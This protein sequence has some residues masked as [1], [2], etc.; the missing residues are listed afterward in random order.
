MDEILPD[1]AREVDGRLEIDGL[2]AA[3]L[4]ERYGTPLMV[5]DRATLEAR[6]DA[7]ASALG[8]DHVFYAAKAFCCVAIC[9]VLAGLGL[10]IDVCTGG[11]LET[12]F[13]AG[14]PPERILFHG[15]NKSE[16]ELERAGEVGVGRI[17]VDSL[18][19]LDRIAKV[20]PRPTS[21][22]A[23]RRGSRPTPTSS[24]RPVKRIRSSALGSETMSL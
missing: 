19:E 15:N 13:A 8:A 4:A 14:F 12:A 18:D 1:R 3:D 24:S 2:L 11:E 23:L 16:A 22:C 10:G 9:E 7:Y 20:G 17:V 21:C 5:V 6:G